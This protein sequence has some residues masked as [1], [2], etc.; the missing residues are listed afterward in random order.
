MDFELQPKMLQMFSPQRRKYFIGLIICSD[1][2]DKSKAVTCVEGFKINFNDKN[3]L[4]LTYNPKNAF[5]RHQYSLKLFFETEI[6]V[7]L[8]KEDLPY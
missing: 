2:V 4:L 1:S 6:T 7:A 3:I 5:R 8:H